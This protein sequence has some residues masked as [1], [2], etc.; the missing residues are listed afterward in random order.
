MIKTANYKMTKKHMNN[1][2]LF[3]VY[4]RLKQSTLR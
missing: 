4:Q 2:Q 1:E 3:I